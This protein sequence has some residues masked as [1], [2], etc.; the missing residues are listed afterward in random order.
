MPPGQEYELVQSLHVLVFERDR[1][2]FVDIEVQVED[3][4]DR[5]RYRFVAE[6][7]CPEELAALFDDAA[8]FLHLET[9]AIE[10]LIFEMSRESTPVA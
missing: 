10:Q 5:V 4:P 3:V 6:R 2:M 1:D 8:H 7:D 9:R